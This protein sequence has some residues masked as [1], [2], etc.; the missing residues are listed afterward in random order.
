M[1][2]DYC[3]PTW[4]SPEDKEDDLDATNDGE[5]SKE[6]HGASNETQLSLRLDL[7]VPLDLVEGGCVKVDLHQLESRLWELLSWSFTRNILDEE[8]WTYQNKS[9]QQDW[10]WNAGRQSFWT[11]C[12]RKQVS[13]ISPC[14]A[15]PLLAD[16]DKD[17]LW[18]ELFEL[19]ELFELFKLFQFSKIF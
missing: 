15:F 14:L 17:T 9:S 18:T 2:F 12:I 8:I 16:R 1:I 13:Y 3:N 11:S 10:I 5:P 6:P 19:S 4:I 7:L